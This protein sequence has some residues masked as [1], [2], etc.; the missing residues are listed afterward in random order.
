[1]NNSRLDELHTQKL[2]RVVKPTPLHFSSKTNE[3]ATP[4]ELYSKL[5]K[6]FNFT[7]DPCS[8]HENAKCDRHYTINEDGLAQSWANE[9]VFMNPPYGREIGLWI[10]KAYNESQRGATVVCLIPART[11]TK[12]W[13]D[14]IFGK[15]EIRFLKGRLKFGDSKNSAPFPS[16]VVIY[17]SRV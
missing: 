1:M 10:E 12:Y 9:T 15:A 14:Y 3:W 16:A 17:R 4:N 7:L 13:H 6:E 8:T 11:D 2:E 5:N